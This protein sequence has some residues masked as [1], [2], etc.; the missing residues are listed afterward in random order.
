MIPFLEMEI[1]TKIPQLEYYA[2][3]LMKLVK[4]QKFEIKTRLQNKV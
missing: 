1:R 2:Y 4:S 3:R